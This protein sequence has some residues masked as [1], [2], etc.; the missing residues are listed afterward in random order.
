[1]K[2]GDAFFAGGVKG[3]LPSH[4]DLEAVLELDI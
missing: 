3:R 1:M 2:R 4:V